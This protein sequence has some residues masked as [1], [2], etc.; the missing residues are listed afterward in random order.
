MK[1]ES[2][3]DI[4][5]TLNDIQNNSELTDLNTSEQQ[6]Q[7]NRQQ[8]NDQK[9]DEKLNELIIKVEKLTEKIAENNDL[10]F[11]NKFKTN[12]K[13][14][15]INEY[16]DNE[17]NYKN[18][19]SMTKS[20][21]RSYGRD[22]NFYPIYQLHDDYYRQQLLNSENFSQNKKTENY[23]NSQILSFT[24]P[25]SQVRQQNPQ[26]FNKSKTFHNN[27]YKNFETNDKNM[28]NKSHFLGLNQKNL[29]FFS[30]YI[31]LIPEV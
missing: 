13:F 27:R 5:P 29:N 9:P 31:S 18:N 7:L 28:Q 25:V 15:D 23:Q 26:L 3:C 6:I 1:I 4:T 21:T 16:E 14:N 22:K 10:L 12:I 24:A 19:K 2:N 8:T 30:K 11:Q 17:M 20:N